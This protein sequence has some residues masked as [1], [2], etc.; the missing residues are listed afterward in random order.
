M[1]VPRRS[2]GADAFGKSLALLI[3]G[4]LAAVAGVNASEIADAAKRGNVASVR[5]L[6]KAA[7]AAA[8]DQ[9]GRDSMTA[10]LWATPAPTRI[11]PTVTA[12]RRCG[13]RRRTAARRS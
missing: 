13:S 12:S 2:G 6:A 8:L 3:C 11:S 5:D 1:R 9:P 4:S 10:L 7:D